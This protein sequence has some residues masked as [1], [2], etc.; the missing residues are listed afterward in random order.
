MDDWWIATVDNK[1]GRRLHTQIIHKFLDL[2]AQQL[3]QRAGLKLL[4]EV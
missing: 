2:D 4:T 1:E 3:V